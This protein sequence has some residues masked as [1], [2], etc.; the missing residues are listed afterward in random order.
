MCVSSFLCLW[1]S[2]FGDNAYLPSRVQV[3]S[4]AVKNLGVLGTQNVQRWL[5]KIFDAF[6]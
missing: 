2:I 1:Y 4:E 6:C 3:N 5:P